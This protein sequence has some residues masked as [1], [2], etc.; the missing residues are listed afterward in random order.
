MTLVEL[1]LFLMVGVTF[2][3]AIVFCLNQ[4]RKTGSNG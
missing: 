4:Y 1:V 2:G 3:G